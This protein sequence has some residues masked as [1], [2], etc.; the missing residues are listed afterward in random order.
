[1]IN[2]LFY[3]SVDCGFL[4]DTKTVLKRTELRKNLL[5]VGSLI[6][7]S[8]VLGF[9]QDKLLIKFFNGISVASDSF[10]VSFRIPNIL[11]KIVGDGM[12][13]AALVPKMIDLN[14]KKEIDRGNKL[15]TF[16]IT[17]IMF[18]FFYF[19]CLYF[20]IL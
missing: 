12:I 19:H 7:L 8:R 6:F 13:G 5:N 15:I 4:V 1:M 18:F 16:F 3:G 9:W 11:G 10:F 17:I 20:Y 2:N 14:S